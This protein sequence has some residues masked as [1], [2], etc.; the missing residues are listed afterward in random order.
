MQTPASMDREVEQMGDEGE[1]AVHTGS[2]QTASSTRSTSHTS[3]IAIQKVI[4]VVG[5]L[6]DYKR[7]LVEEIGFDGVLRIPMIQKINLKFSKF[8]M[9]KVVVKDHCIILRDGGTPITFY[10]EDFHKVFSIPCGEQD[11]HGKDAEITPEAIEFIRNSIG[12]ADKSDRSLSSVEVFIGKEITELSSRLEK[13]CFKMAFVVF[14]MGNLFAP[15]TKH[16]HST[17]DYWGAISDTDNI[18]L[19]NWC[20]YSFEGL[21][22]AIAKLKLETDAN[23]SVNNLSGC[24][25]FLQVFVLDNVDLGILNLKQ[26]K[27]PRIELFDGATLKRMILMCSVRKDGKNIYIL[28]E[29]RHGTAVCYTRHNYVNVKHAKRAIEDKAEGSANMYAVVTH[30]PD[31]GK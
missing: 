5:A 28:P 7:F 8:L 2:V 19:F 26:T 1:A 15:C 22:E 17:I 3:R 10:P 11:I 13:D 12:W 21:L 20:K 31:V 25:L 27:I 18:A 6:S 24:H 9:S 4:D 16:D 23:I 14:V 30:N 29:A